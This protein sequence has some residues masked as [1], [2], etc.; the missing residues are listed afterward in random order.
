MPLFLHTRLSCQPGELENERC[1]TSSIE[2]I[3]QAQ[4]TVC[5]N[6][7]KHKIN[8]ILRLLYL[9]VC[10]K[11]TSRRRLPSGG[12]GN[13]NYWGIHGIAKSCSLQ[14]SLCASTQTDWL[15]F[16]WEVEKG[17][18]ALSFAAFACQLARFAGHTKAQLTATNKQIRAHLPGRRRQS[19]PLITS[20][21]HTSISYF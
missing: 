17:F 20:V 14:G 9:R 10:K 7:S 1:F 21:L 11:Q 15:M 16:R 6:C 2:K 12:E 18:W 19:S 8:I 13:T 4:E 5:T 3:Q